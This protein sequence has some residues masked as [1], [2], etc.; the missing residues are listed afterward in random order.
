MAVL[1]NSPTPGL[2]TMEDVIAASK[3]A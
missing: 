1:V 3:P 2:R